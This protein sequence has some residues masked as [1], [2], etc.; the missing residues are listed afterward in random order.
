MFEHLKPYSK[1][2]VTGLARSG[3]RI[4][5][6]MIA[7]DTGKEFI[8]ETEWGVWDYEKLKFFCK[9]R[10]KFVIQ[11][12]SAFFNLSEFVTDDDMVVWMERPIKE[13]EESWKRIRD[14][15]K[16]GRSVFHSSTAKMPELFRTSFDE[17]VILAEE[18]KRKIKNLFEV[19]YHS[20]KDH[21]MWVDKD[22]RNKFLWMQTDENQF[23]EPS[24]RKVLHNL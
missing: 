21:P 4:A 5:T 17:R 20:L 10:D 15:G 14:L 12:T 11:A 13:L 7:H 8:D 3:T 1:I 2:F 22:K 6:R 23:T 24:V 9:Y 18:E 19:N 16:D